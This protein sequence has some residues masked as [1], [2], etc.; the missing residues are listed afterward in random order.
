M[1]RLFTKSLCTSSAAAAN[2]KPPPPDPAAISKLILSSPIQSPLSPNTPW[3][4]HLVNSILKRLWNHG[5]KALHFF[6]LLDRRHRSYIHSPSSFNLAI[7]IAARLHLH[8]T[9]WSLIRRMRSLRIGPSPKTF[10]IVAERFA[11]SGKPDKAVN[12]FLN[13]HEHG[14]SQDLA[15]FNT[16]LDV[17]CKSKRVEKAYELFKDL[18]GRFS[19]DVVTYNVIVNG[20]CLIKR[21]P[22]AL[23]VL[24]EMVERGITPNLTTY[25]TMLKGFFRSG[26][27]RQ[28]W[29][30]FLEMKKRN[31]GIGIGIDVVTYT[32]VVHGLGVAG[33]VKR[34]KKVFDEMIREGVL[35]SVATH[36]ALIQVLCK[37]DTVENAVSVFEE[38]VR[39]GYEPNVTTYNVLIRGLFHAGEFTR[40][41]EMMRTME[42]EGGCEASFQTYNM[43]MRYYLECGEVEK[44]LG[45]FERMGSGGCLPNLDT[46]NILISG[47]FVRKR[48]E[49]MV[50]AGKL[51][52]EMVE[53]GFVPRKFTFNRVLNGLLLTGNQGFAKEILRSQSKSGSR[54]TKKFRL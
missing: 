21:T 37:K 20:W 10:A 7:D 13:M 30:F 53:R 31:C 33:E 44:A 17:L 54:L 49:D 47:M 46:Y 14:C 52:V 42:E 4:P 36:N 12:L 40:G 22:K 43:M 26:Q 3:T 11:S 48:S 24:K 50:V 9:V 5:P 2:L 51:L 32:T 8:T 38:M 16:I 19:A 34:A 23:E 18:R 25:N 45:L 27:V 1:N 39:K 29:E 41:E 6:H 35:P 15:S 28:G